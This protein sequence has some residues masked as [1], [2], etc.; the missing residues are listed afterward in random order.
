[1]NIV[2]KNSCW[3]DRDIRCLFGDEPVIFSDA[4]NITDLVVEL[5]L[6]KS[7]S[8]ARNAGR[9]GDIP[10]GWSEVKGNKI[11]TLWIWNPTE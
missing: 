7:K 11:T 5:G 3:T 2:I 8:Q 6:Y 1:M 4:D 10:K 9:T